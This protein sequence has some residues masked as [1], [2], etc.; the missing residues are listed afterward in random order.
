MTQQNRYIENKSRNS[1]TNVRRSPWPLQKTLPTN[2]LSTTSWWEWHPFP[3]FE[4][5]AE[6][7]PEAAG[8]C[9]RPCSRRRAPTIEPNK[10]VAL[11]FHL[12]GC[13][14]VVVRALGSGDRVHGFKSR[15]QWSGLFCGL[16]LLLLSFFF[17]CHSLS[18]L[19][20]LIV[21]WISCVTNCNRGGKKRVILEK[22]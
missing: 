2:L 17:S 15:L 11:A 9:G 4:L 3:P 5:P 12:I 1:S 14:G 10:Y 7:L 22:S 20:W 8:W 13:R 18:L 21:M 19:Q 16:F 6:F